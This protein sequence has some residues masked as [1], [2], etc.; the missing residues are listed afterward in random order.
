MSEFRY[1][2]CNQ[3]TMILSPRT[4]H[5][6]YYSIIINNRLK[7]NSNDGMERKNEEKKL[8][9]ENRWISRWGTVRK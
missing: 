7:I 2:C 5:R 1:G 4:F 6:M 3:F 8:P 9:L